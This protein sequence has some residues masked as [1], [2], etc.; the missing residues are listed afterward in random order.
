MTKQSLKELYYLAIFGKPPSYDAYGHCKLSHREIARREYEHGRYGMIFRLGN[1]DEFVRLEE[2]RYNEKE[3]QI[4]LYKRR[5]QE[6]KD[7]NE[8]RKKFE[9]HFEAALRNE[10]LPTESD[11]P[12]GFDWGKPLHPVHYRRFKQALSEYNS[13]VQLSMQEAA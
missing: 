5:I 3:H 7:L 11:S 4:P 9:L 10:T 12:Y 1:T 6:L 13:G 8:E 2:Q